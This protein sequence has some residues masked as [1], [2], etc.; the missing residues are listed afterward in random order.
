MRDSKPLRALLHRDDGVA[1][2]TVVGVMLVVTLVAIGSFTLAQQAL[3]ESTRTVDETRA[4]RAAAAGID[5]VLATFNPE[6]V[7]P[8]STGATPD[9]SY[10]VLLGEDGGDGEFK[11]VSE[12]VGLDGSKERLVQRF[13]YFNLWKMNFAGMGPQSLI[14][15]TSG[16]NGSSNIVGPFYM[17]GPIYIDANMAVLEGPL[18]VNGGTINVGA[19]GLL[20]NPYNPIKVYCDQDIIGPAANI[21]VLSRSVSVPD[22]NLP[23]MSEAELQALSTLSQTESMDGLMGSAPDDTLDTRSANRETASQPGPYKFIGPITSEMSLPAGTGTTN[24]V[25]GPATFGH[26]G[27]ITYPE[28]GVNI[29]MRVGEAVYTAADDDR[30]DDFAY[31]DNV[32]GLDGWDLLFIN[33]TVFIDGSLTLNDHVYYIGNGTIVANGTITVKNKVRPFGA[34]N[35]VGETMHWALGLVTPTNITFETQENPVPIDMSSETAVDTVRNRL[36]DLAGAFYADD[37]V[38]FTGNNIMVRGSILAGKME[39]A[40]NNNVLVTNPLLPDYIPA[41][42]P[43]AKEGLLIPGNWSR[44]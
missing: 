23:R 34:T 20:G 31:W 38:Y 24:L 43:G 27:P 32:P 35:T 18:F 10:T 7:P 37:R 1:M 25:L 26:W 42:M 44:E 8:T 13:Y 40:Q 5:T 15:G 4:F 9:G 14:T 36:P 22:I 11:L 16:L 28:V 21:N 39:M 30:F 19:S 6:S 41:S 2:A 33:G 12:G 3:Y 29:P 17:E